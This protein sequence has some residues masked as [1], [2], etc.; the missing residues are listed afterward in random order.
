MWIL[1]LITYCPSKF[2]SI[3]KDVSLGRT[4]LLD[5]TIESLDTYCYMRYC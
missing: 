1:K 4:V 2:G 3:A 5:S